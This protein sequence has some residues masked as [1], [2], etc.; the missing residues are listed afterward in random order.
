MMLMSKY[1]PLRVHLVE[2]PPGPVAMSFVE[3]ERLVGQLPQSA[4]DHDAWWLDASPNATHV[5]SRAWRDA[6]RRVVKVDRRAKIVI[7]GSRQCA[8]A[9]GAS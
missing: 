3:I 9:S 6:G 1:E 8:G 5:Q 4:H 7:F 2:E